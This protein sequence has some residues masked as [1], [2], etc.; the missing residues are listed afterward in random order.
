MIE[1]LAGL[2][3]SLFGISLLRINQEHNQS[4]CLSQNFVASVL[5]VDVGK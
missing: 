2:N 5:V 1:V 4:F 3:N